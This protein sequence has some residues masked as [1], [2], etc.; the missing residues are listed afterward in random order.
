ML[1]YIPKGWNAVGLN[2]PKISQTGL[3]TM[4][5]TSNEA[6]LDIINPYYLQLKLAHSGN[7]LMLRY[8][9]FPLQS[10]CYLA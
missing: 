10:H 3:I 4:F 5:G 6:I 7:H 9:C 1:R 8:R 2:N